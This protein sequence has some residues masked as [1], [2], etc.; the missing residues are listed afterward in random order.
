MLEIVF[1][2]TV[3]LT[4]SVVSLWKLRQAETQIQARLL[5]A[6]QSTSLRRRQVVQ[7]FSEIYNP[8]LMA[9]AVGD[10][11]CRFNARSALIRCAV[12]P[13]GPCEGCRDYQPRE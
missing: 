8:V 5:S 7:E 1:I 3:A 13:D 2:F 4:P 9:R 6:R 12:N 10:E 11:N